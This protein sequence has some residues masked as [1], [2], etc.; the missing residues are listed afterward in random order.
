MAKQIKLSAQTRTGVGRSAVNKIKTQ[1]AVPAVIYGGKQAPQPLQ[2][3]AR[4]IAN[5]L[6]HASGEN[7][8][9]DLEIEAAGQKASRM[10]LIQ[11]IQH[12]PL[13]G[14]VLHIDF[15]AVSADQK[16][17]TN[18]PIEPFGESAGVKGFGGILEQSMRTLEVE[19]LPKDLPDIITV[20]VSALNIG[21]TIHV[22]DIKLPP[23]VTATV[24]PVLS[25]FHVISP[26]KIEAAEEAAIAAAAAAPTAPEVLK[27]KKVEGA[28]A[29]AEKGAEKKGGDKKGGD[30]K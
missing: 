8:L 26:T 16:I 29:A 2:V 15:L 25:V 24:E 5:I 30:K 19:C 23:G 9:V 3:A 22:G 6:A 18:I 7:V 14:K 28:P 4:D 17:T 11:E 12:H 27:E 21:D 20:D 1:G 10:A 13:S